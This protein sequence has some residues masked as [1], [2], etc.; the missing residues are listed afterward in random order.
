MLRKIRFSIV[1]LIAFSAT[2]AWAKGSSSE[3]LVGQRVHISQGETRDQDL[4]CIACRITVDGTMDGDVVLVGGSLDVTGS[5]TGDVAVFAAGANLGEHARMGGDVAV[6][7]GRLTRAPGAEIAGDVAAPRTSPARVGAGLI[8]GLAMAFLVPVAIMGFLAVLL[9]FAIL[10]ER[11]IAA[12]AGAIQLHAGLAL[13]AGIIAC[14]ALGFL[15]RAVHFA[16]LHLVVLLF[17]CAALVTGYS[18]LSLLMGRRIARNSRVLA[19]I[20]VGA[21]VI[22]A[23]QIVPGLGW[24]V[25]VFFACLALGG[26]ILSGF[27][28]SPDWYEQRGRPVPPAGATAG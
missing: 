5:I 2:S 26:C 13:L 8:V 11:R 20:M 12:V 17:F 4:V 19:M 16:A 6:I 18:G 9:A 1:L 7:G 22:A 15:A 14:V 3:V 25:F 28:S 23:I 27:G 21:V 24:V 10:G